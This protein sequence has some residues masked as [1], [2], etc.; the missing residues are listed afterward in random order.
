MVLLL[1]SLAVLVLGKN[2]NGLILGLEGEILPA[3]KKKNKYIKYL[4][5]RWER[6]I[7]IIR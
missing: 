2:G 3:C 7:T 6:F 4:Y 1:S 5:F